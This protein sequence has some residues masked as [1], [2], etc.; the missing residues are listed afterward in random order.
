MVKPRTISGK[1]GLTG[2]PPAGGGATH[3]HYGVLRLPLVARKGRYDLPLLAE[4]HRIPRLQPLRPGLVTWG[5]TELDSEV[6][7]AEPG[8]HSPATPGGRRDSGAGGEGA[9]E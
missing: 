6:L 3:P 9:K 7:W 1:D 8:G 5:T 2:T 4:D